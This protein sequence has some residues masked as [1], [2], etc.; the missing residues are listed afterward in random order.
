MSN[1][2]RMIADISKI[3][4]KPILSELKNYN[5]LYRHVQELMKQDEFSEDL[6]SYSEFIGLENTASN[7]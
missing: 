1:E 2:G 4:C 6:A 5:A 7:K 3:N